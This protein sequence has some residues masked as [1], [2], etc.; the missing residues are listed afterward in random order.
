MNNITSGFM[1][2]WI[3]IK[4]T[5]LEVAK[6]DEAKYGWDVRLKGHWVKKRKHGRG[7]NIWYTGGYYQKTEELFVWDSMIDS[8]TEKEVNLDPRVTFRGDSG[9]RVTIEL[10]R[11]IESI[12]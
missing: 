10:R 7:N 8:D 4:G 9:E 11:I 1:K 2:R 6:N 5:W 3:S 12:D